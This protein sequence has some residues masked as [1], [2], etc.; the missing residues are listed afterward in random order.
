MKQKILFV[1]LGNICRSPAAEGIMRTIVEN[2]GH[3]ADFFIDSAG[4]G[5]WHVGQLPDSRMRKQGARHGYDFR[6][7]ARQVTLSDF[8][9]FDIIVAMDDDNK[10]ALQR[11]AI[12]S[13]GK[14]R[15]VMMADYLTEHPGQRDIPDP[16]YGVQGD[17]ERVIE[18]LE[19]SCHGLY[20]SLEQ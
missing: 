4:L 3:E 6:S 19:D 11:M 20:A 18:L 16:Y 15:I 17:F 9:D 2:E 7:R 14:A 13:G 12:N 1:C 10:R 8:S 5:N